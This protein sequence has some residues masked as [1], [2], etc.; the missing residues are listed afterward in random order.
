M[1]KFKKIAIGLV[2]L[3]LLF[4]CQAMAQG[5]GGAKDNLDAVASK[6]GTQTESLSSLIGSIINVV[7]SLVGI[8]FLAFMVYAGMLW[9]TSRGE[10]E[11]VGKA[12]KIIYTSIIGLVITVSAYAIT[13]FVTAKFGD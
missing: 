3:G 1:L 13:V 4:S 6:T 10:E 7:L 11:Q 8:I 5:I 12:Q 2:A 9:M